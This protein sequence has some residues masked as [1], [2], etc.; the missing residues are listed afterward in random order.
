MKLKQFWLLSS[1]LCWQLL[2]NAQRPA[3]TAAASRQIAFKGAEGFGA[4][5]AGGRGGHLYHVTNLEDSGPG[6]F[7]EGVSQSHRIIV[8][9]TAGVIR[10]KS[11]VNVAGHITINGQSAPAPGI[12]LYGA[13]IAFN[14]ISEVVVRYLRLH[15]SINMSRGS[16][17]LIAD[18]SDQLIFDHV[19]VTW[20][21]WDNVHIKGSSN[22]TLQYCLIGES[23]DPQRF[24]A[25]LEGPTRLS[26]HHSLWIDNQSRNPKAKAEIEFVN[27]VVYNW[28]TSGFVGGH[29]AAN[30][31][32][33]MIGNY[34]MAGPSSTTNFLSM[35]TGTDHVYHSDN[36]VDLNKDGIL[37]GVSFTDKDFVTKTGQPTIVR[38]KQ[39]RPPVPITTTGAAAAF[40]AVLQSAGA[41][42]Y[43]DQVD[44]R[45]IH[46][47]VSKGT[48]GA[49]IW[50]ETQVGGQAK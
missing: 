6:S 4:L 35:F 38:E 7:R 16:C 37:N 48:E 32:Q 24:G 21:R 43:R 12:T 5:A 27:N 17:V 33:D 49:V 40:A 2:V 1:L 26:V 25:L 3:A 50:T 36:L 44:Q 18:N 28:G 13:S 22:I 15:G 39:S 41:S 34:F 45:L 29:S 8:F 30:H 47:L 23:L 19:S 10:L 42:N 20:G 9:D 46:Q 14:K 11:R 31:Y